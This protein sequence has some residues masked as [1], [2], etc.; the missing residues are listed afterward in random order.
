MRQALAEWRGG[1]IEAAISRLDRSGRVHIADN[2][3]DLLAAVTDDWYADR[4]RRAA[5]PALEASSMVTE[6]HR[7]RRELNTLA[8]A[9]LV[10][11]GTL[12]GPVLR[13]GEL[14][15]QRGDEVIALEQDRDL[16]P[17]GSKR[18]GDFVHTA[19]RGVVVDVNLPRRGGRLRGR[20]LHPPGPRRR[21]DGLPDPSPRQRY[22]G[23]AGP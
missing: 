9:K 16:R 2:R 7:D 10:K 14:E 5:E 13:A 6:R 20:R 4:Q 8:R 22:R 15:F 12:S 18:R 3:D 23:S 17:E 19:E 1:D 11:D 21:A